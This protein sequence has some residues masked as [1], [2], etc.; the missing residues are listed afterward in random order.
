MTVQVY[1]PAKPTTEGH[2]IN[3]AA[4]DVYGN[5]AFLNPLSPADWEG[6]DQDGQWFV[7]CATREVA[8]CPCGDL[9]CRHDLGNPYLY[10]GR[11]CSIARRLREHCAQSAWWPLAKT[12]IVGRAASKQDSI[13][14]EARYIQV[15]NPIFNKRRP[16]VAL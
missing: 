1:G 6:A 11:T 9:G 4:F 7:Y 14:W 8:A 10:V 5:P 12:I 2:Q 3:M 16:V 15:A 13:D